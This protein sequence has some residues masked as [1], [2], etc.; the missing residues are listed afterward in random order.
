MKA[1]SSLGHNL[2]DVKQFQNII[3]SLDTPQHREKKR[4]ENPI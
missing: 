2:K 3:N 1:Q 4:K